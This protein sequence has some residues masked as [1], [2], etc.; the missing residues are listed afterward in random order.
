MNA[1]G[2]V[3]NFEVVKE[4]VYYPVSL[5]VERDR[6]FFEIT[7]DNIASAHVP[8]FFSKPFRSR[9]AHLYSEGDGVA[10]VYVGMGEWQSFADPNLPVAFPDG[11][12]A[13]EQGIDALVDSLTRIL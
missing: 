1:W 12:D 4:R 3:E 8:L 11:F 6:D 7:F 5:H 13:S 10:G 2:D 9:L